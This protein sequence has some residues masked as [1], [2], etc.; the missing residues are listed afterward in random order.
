MYKNN[1]ILK[2]GRSTYAI[3]IEVIVFM[4]KDMR[5]IRVHTKNNVIEFYGKFSEISKYLDERFMY[6][7][8]IYIINMDEI[9]LMKRQQIYVSSNDCIA[10]GRDAYSRARKAYGDYIDAGDE[11]RELEVKQ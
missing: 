3:P 7:H 11:K 4:E 2:S 9:V 5:K 8:R 6:C 10:L 1:M